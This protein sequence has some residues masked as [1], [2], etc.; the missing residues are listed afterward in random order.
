MKELTLDEMK[1]TELGLL[2]EFHQM[3]VENGWRYS[4]SGGTLLGAVR[5]HGFIPWDDDIDVMMPRPDYDQFIEYCG[6]HPT[7]FKV[8]SNELTENYYL[9][10]AKISDRKTLIED[11]E[12][13][14]PD[15]G[16]GV[17]IDVFP[18]DG[19]A[20]TYNGAKKRFESTSLKRELLGASAW[21]KYF[22]S[23]THPVYMEPVR[24]AVFAASRAVNRKRLLLSVEKTNRG[25]PFDTSRFAGCVCGSYRKNEI[26]ETDVFREYEDILFEGRQLK[27]IRGKEIY[28]QHLYGD[29][30]KLPPEEKRVTHHTFKAYKL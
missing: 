30:M 14:L 6:A 1:A 4:L 28:L 15:Y 29:Y 9:L 22:R 13:V 11:A 3:C 8:F 27:A 21:K 23:K 17:S 24:F 26:M 18:I 25:V 10:F 2:L 12:T 7:A 19:L 16:I 20:E 5:H